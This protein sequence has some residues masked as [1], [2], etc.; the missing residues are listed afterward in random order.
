MFPNDAELVVTKHGSIY[1]EVIIKVVKH[2]NH[3][4]GKTV[5]ANEHILLLLD[6]HSSRQGEAWLHECE[7]QQILIVKLPTN[8]THLLQLCDQS[9][10]KC[11]QR[12]VRSTRDELLTMSHLSWANTAFKLKLAVAGHSALT[13]DIARKSFVGAGLWPMNYQFMDGFEPSQVRENTPPSRSLTLPTPNGYA[14]RADFMAQSRRESSHLLDKVRGL[15][16]GG[17]SAQKTLAAIQVLPNGEF[18]FS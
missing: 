3:H 8:T 10:N 14:L 16:N 6:G 12:T 4:A 11:F 1:K 5:P 15:S 17:G 9:V 13:P 7:K 18:K 2:I